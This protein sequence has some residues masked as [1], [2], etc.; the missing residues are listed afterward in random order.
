MAIVGASTAGAAAAYALRAEGHEGPVV[1]IGAEQ[2]APYERPPLSKDVLTSADDPQPL[3]LLTPDTYVSTNIELRL[4][5]AVTSLETDGSR[6]RL[7]LADGAR[8]SAD[9]VVL[10]TGGRARRLDVLPADPR[11]HVLRTWADAQALRTQ[12]RAADRALVLGSGLIGAECAASAS[13]QGVE[14]EVIE[15]QHVPFPSL[16]SHEVRGALLRT[17][18]QHGVTFRTGVTV[19]GCQAGSDGLIVSLSDGNVIETDLI[20]IGIGVEPMTGLADQ[21]GAE[22]QRGV[23]VDDRMRTSV[24]GLFAAGDVATRRIGDRLVRH[25]HFASAQAQGAAV[26]RSV[27]GLDPVAPP[28]AWAW[29]DQ[30]THRLD[31]VGDPQGGTERRLRRGD[32]GSLVEFSLAGSR[33]VGV[34]ALDAHRTVRDARRLIGGVLRAPAEGLE[35]NDVPLKQ[36]VSTP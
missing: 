19:T 25:E 34:T 33:L 18:A 9:T 27:V 12:L 6:F 24:P 23:L 30:F 21:L 8:L 22:T 5:A 17:F 16:P 20:V 3:W 29:S 14:V 2:T 15:A 28:A 35:G 13:S 10:A 11:I 36:L 31:V 26:A 1:L 7:A 32:D 4:G